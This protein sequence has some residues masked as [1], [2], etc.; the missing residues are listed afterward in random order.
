MD[1]LI[2]RTKQIVFSKQTNMFSST[3]VI[4]SMVVVARLFGFPRYRTLVHFFT[5]GEL[6]IFFAAFRIPDLVFEI[7]IT[8]A[9][10]TSFI[11]FFIKYDRR[12]EA[13]SIVIS[14]IMNLILAVLTLSVAVLSL[15][16]P[17]IIPLIT[18]GFSPEKV[19]TIVYFSRLLLLGQLPFLILGNLLTGLSQARKMFLLPA[20]APIIYNLAIIIATLFLAPSSH[21]LAP[22]IGVM[23]GAVLFFLIQLPTVRIAEFSYQIIFK[24][25][26]AIWDF[27]RVAVPRIFTVIVAQV[28]ATIDLSLTSLLGSGSY[29]VFY[30]AQHLQLLPISV[31]GVAYGQASLPYLSE[32][33]QEED[34]RKFKKIIPDSILSLLFMIIPLAGFFVFARTPLVRIFFGAQKFDW[35]ATNMTALTLSAFAFSMPAHSIY[36]FLTRCFYAL[37]DSKTPFYMSFTAVLLN[38]TMSIL[39][40]LVFKL[41]VWALG[42]SFSVSMSLNTLLLLYVLYKKIGGYN[43][44]IIV[45]ELAKITFA[46][47]IASYASH[48]LKS[49]FDEL[50]FDTTRTINVFLLLATIFLF[51]IVLYLFIAWLLNVREL[52]LI[53]KMLFKM[54]Q[55]R[56]KITE[57]YTGVQ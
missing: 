29:T 52:Y 45:V 18:P 10:T 23:S 15:L 27:F 17:Y 25:T 46:A 44:R 5:K 26:K 7:L 51:F 36:Y 48:K 37:F 43:I 2:D 19:D 22:V 14:S 31:I 41:P 54:K 35:A 20:V 6:D 21:L 53:T 50:I 57:L 13:Q 16:M 38:A 32:L 24:K 40:V 55:F 9:L 42:F 28:D 11:P 56:R 30:L 39:F 34:L 3:I 49:L 47:F 8:G 1:K 12:K 33:A 4:G